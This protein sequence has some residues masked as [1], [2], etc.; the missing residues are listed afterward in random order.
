MGLSWAWFVTSASDDLH[1]R[2]ATCLSGFLQGSRFWIFVYG[3]LA[4]CLAAL[5]CVFF[6]VWRFLSRGKQPRRHVLISGAFG[7]GKHVAADLIGRLFGLLNNQIVAGGWRG[8]TGE[9]GQMQGREGLRV[10]LLTCAVVK[11]HGMTW[12]SL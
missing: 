1:N 12:L 11:S 7:V 8:R 6:G 2:K 9:V 4:L 10:S 5:A 3:L